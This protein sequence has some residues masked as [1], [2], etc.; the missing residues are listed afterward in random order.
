[1]QDFDSA[2]SFHA[3]ALVQATLSNYTNIF[4]PCGDLRQQQA[5]TINKI[6]TNLEHCLEQLSHL[7]G[8][9]G[10][11]YPALLTYHELLASA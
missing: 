8:I 4:V 10:N 9:A 3:Y 5:E 7:G 1:M 6:I 2:P 11:F